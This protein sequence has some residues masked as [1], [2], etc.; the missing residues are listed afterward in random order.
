MELRRFIITLVPGVLVGLSISGVPAAQQSPTLVGFLSGNARDQSGPQLAAFH[1]GLS[2]AGC[3]EGRNIVLEYRFAD[4]RYERLPMLAAELLRNKVAAVVATGGSLSARAVQGESPSTP[5]VML[6]G[7]DPVQ[8]DSIGGVSRAA[9]NVTG[10]SVYT[11]PLA[12]KRLEFLREIMPHATRIGVLVNP[13]SASAEVEARDLSAAIAATGARTVVL[14]ASTDTALEPA[15]ASAEGI[16][17]LMVSADPFLNSRRARVAALAAQRRLPT[18]YPWR[19]DVEAG[20]LMSYGPRLTEA[21][22]ELG[23]YT[24]RILKGVSPGELPI[25]VPHKL[26]LVI[27]LRTAGALGLTIPQ[28]LLARADETIE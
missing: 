20:G 8:L 16:D 24:G 17:A 14:K 26:E 19:E 18:I 6:T 9:G 15:F 4:G 7:F 23:R 5:I 3:V 21:Y 1:R 28:V 27:N 2:E 12:A 13:T 11:M 22:R 10:V 25:Q